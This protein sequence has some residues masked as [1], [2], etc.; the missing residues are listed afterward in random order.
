MTRHGTPGRRHPGGAGTRRWSSGGMGRQLGSNSPFAGRARGLTDTGVNRMSDC[1]WLNGVWIAVLV[2]GALS[3]RGATAVE[4]FFDLGDQS[5]GVLGGPLDGSNPVLEVWPGQTASLHLWAIPDADD[6]KVVAA[7]GHDVLVSGPAAAWVSATQYTLDNPMVGTNPRWSGISLV[8]GLN[9]PGK[10]V[11]DQRA[12]SVPTE[13]PFVGG[14]GSG[15]L[16]IDPAYDANSGAVYL[17]QLDLQIDP[18]A[19][20]GTRAEL[21]LSVSP[22]LIAQVTTGVWQEEPVSFGFVL[23]GGA[24]PATGSGS[25]AGAGSVIAD[26]VISI[27]PVN[28]SDID[29]DGNVDLTDFASFVACTSGPGNPPAPTCPVGTNADLDGDCD[30][31]LADFAVFTRDFT[32]NP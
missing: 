19:A 17:G 10:L 23:C 7:L 12:V 18:A 2:L 31:D 6:A 5:T 11:D 28:L 32:G 8:G 13:A 22:L 14:I 24:E 15:N 16:D 4:L 3:P 9:T 25:V 1:R 21:R 26:A 30:V 27:G 20:L 29:G